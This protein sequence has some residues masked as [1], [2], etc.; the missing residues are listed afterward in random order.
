VAHTGL[1]L[2]LFLAGSIG[3]SDANVCEPV[4]GR[5]VDLDRQCYGDPIELGG[6]RACRTRTEKGIALECV[7]SPSGELFAVSRNTAASYEGSGFRHGS[8]LTAD[9]T[10][11]CQRAS[12]EIGHPEPRNTC[13]A[14]DAGP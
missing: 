7:A 13:P 12:S 9:E 3:C 5:R 6:L 8:S 11:L 1:A 10:A 4:V 2:A 14:T